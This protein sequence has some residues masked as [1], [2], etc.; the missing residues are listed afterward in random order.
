MGRRTITLTTDSWTSE[1][2]ENFTAVTAHFID[3]DW[4]IHSFVTPLR[5]RGFL[6]QYLLELYIHL[7][8]LFFVSRVTLC[9][10]A[11]G[12]RSDGES[13][14][15]DI[16]AACNEYG[17]D[18]TKNILCVTSDTAANMVVLG[19]LFQEQSEEDIPRHWIGCFAHLIELTTS[20][21]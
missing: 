11:Y 17:I 21:S 18:V 20:N 2:H 15:A 19:R 8:N 3:D 9:C 14:L 4:D 5:P 10:K 7:T 16:H 12:G 6:A 13:I 1:S